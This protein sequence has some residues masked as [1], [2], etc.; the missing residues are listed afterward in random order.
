LPIDGEAKSVKIK[1]ANTD[2]EKI[3]APVNETKKKP[4]MWYR[5]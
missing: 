2:N 4:L 1:E 3:L 5:L